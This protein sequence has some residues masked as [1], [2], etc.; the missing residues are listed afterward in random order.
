MDSFIFLR[1][2]GICNGYAKASVSISKYSI[3]KELFQARL[4]NTPNSI[5]FVEACANGAWYNT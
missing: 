3:K 4:R 5:I 2:L 1:V